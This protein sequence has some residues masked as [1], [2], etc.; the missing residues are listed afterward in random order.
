MTPNV[1][2][3]DLVN[4]VAEYA[5]SEGN[6]RHRRFHGEPGACPALRDLQGG[7]LRSHH[8]RG[9]LRIGDRCHQAVESPP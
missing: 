9:S 1:T 3:L 5:H 7:P 8:A 4:A 2:L 6:H